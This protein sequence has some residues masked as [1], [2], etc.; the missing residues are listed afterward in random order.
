MAP[1]RQ[2]KEIDQVALL[3]DGQAEVVISV[4]LAVTIL[5]PDARRLLRA[6]SPGWPGGGPPGEVTLHLQPAR[7]PTS[8]ETAQRPVQRPQGHSELR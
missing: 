3:E 1:H 7:G 2:L 5:L 4:G 8:G 6:T